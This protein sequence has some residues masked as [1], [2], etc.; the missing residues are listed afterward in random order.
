[1]FDGFNGLDETQVIIKA[2][3]TNLKYSY[4]VIK[5]GIYEDKETFGIWVSPN[6]NDIKEF[7][8][9]SFYT[10]YATLIDFPNETC[11]QPVTPTFSLDFPLPSSPSV[12][13]PVQPRV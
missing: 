10:A 2:G 9:D 12:Y 4:R 1:M 3:E 13:Y 8:L 6:E 11:P 7:E 5:D